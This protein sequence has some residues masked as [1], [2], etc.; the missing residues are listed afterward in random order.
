M[1]SF[2]Q[3]FAGRT[4]FF[5]H[6]SYVAGS[7]DD[8]QKNKGR[9]VRAPG[10]LKQTDYE[11]H[12]AGQQSIG[13]VPIA[14]GDTVSFFCIDVDIYGNA[15][16]APICKRVA[17]LSLPLVPFRTKSWGLHLFC[18]LQTPIPA[19]QAREIARGW[20][21]ALDLDKQGVEVFPKQDSLRGTDF[22]GSAINLPLCG[23]DRPAL[24]VDGEPVG[25]G[26]ALAVC[27]ALL[28][29]PP[30]PEKDAAKVRRKRPRDEPF[31][32][33]MEIDPHKDLPPCMEVAL[34]NPV[35]DGE[36]RD[37][38][39]LHMALVFYKGCNGDLDLTTNALHYWQAQMLG[40]PK[41]AATINRIVGQCSKGYQY[42]C[43]IEPCASRCDKDECAFRTWGIKG[44]Q[45]GGNVIS[46][47]ITAVE[48]LYAA[49][50]DPHFEITV[51]GHA[52][53]FPTLEDATAYERFCNMVLK[54]SNTVF[55]YSNKT[56][57]VWAAYLRPLI[58]DIGVHSTRAEAVELSVNGQI[59]DAFKQFAIHKV[60]DHASSGPPSN[61]KDPW[62]HYHEGHGKLYVSVRDFMKECNRPMDGMKVRLSNVDWALRKEGF[63]IEHVAGN[64]YWTCVG[65]PEWLMRT[66][67]NVEYAPWA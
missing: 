30:L 16:H 34:D 43:S 14:G 49:S 19:K 55:A 35:K 51:N 10:E 66:E 21:V 50:G 32:D 15:N 47:E 18:F 11:A 42:Q 44:K 53:Y 39:L 56:N 38:F 6:L 63:A 54:Q 27:N 46:G 45:T 13:V 59:I 31:K 60:S 36:L 4:E 57:P 58:A 22:L 28:W 24:D 48:I 20:K 25:T 33:P 5:T 65:R 37:Q 17:E 64:D 40:E 1:R 12:L 52:I 2:A 3:L 29:T 9:V 41:D 26:E 61:K 7:V 67:K 23:T 62:S 8:G